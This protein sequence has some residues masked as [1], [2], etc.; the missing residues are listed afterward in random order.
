MPKVSIILP[1]YNVGRYIPEAIRSLQAQTLS[2][3][4][5]IVINDG[6]S[7][8]TLVQLKIIESND[9]RIKLVS[10]TNTGIV[11]ALNEALGY[12]TGQF[13][14]RMDGDDIS[15]PERLQ[16]QVS[17]LEENP[18]ILLV[19]SAVE[20]VD[21]KN[22]RLK[23]YIPPCA[24]DDI[25]K[26]LLDGNS[27]ALIHPTVMGRA[28]AWKAIGPYREAF[29]FVEDYDLFLRASAIGPLA[30]I[31]SPLLRYR[32]HA[33]STN[34][35]RRDIQIRLH[36]ELW[37]NHRKINNLPVSSPP[38]VRPTDQ[39]SMASVYLEWAEWA[40]SGNEFKTALKYASKGLLRKPHSKTALKLFLYALRRS[41]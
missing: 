12:C 33:Q 2:D 40:I 10:R 36:H 18:S 21:S 3:F 25:M 28:T 1:A 31:P 39:P 20:F 24:P 32:V 15:L 6:S 8:N 26:A 23:S 7:D 4:E 30:N 14:A 11:G 27:G 41:L 5:V 17:F 19:G 29:K 22:R 34:Y 38:K 16:R 13:I 9:Y 37:A 35:K